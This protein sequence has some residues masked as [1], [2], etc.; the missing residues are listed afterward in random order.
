QSVKDALA[1]KSNGVIV[2]GRKSGVA[3]DIERVKEVK[4]AAG[5]NDVILGSG[6]NPENVSELLSVA[7]AAIVGTS[8]STGTG[9]AVIREKVRTYM[10]AVKKLRERLN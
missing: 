4:A 2:T 7:D 9:G 3:P 6:T 5:E 10:N 8:I 1:G